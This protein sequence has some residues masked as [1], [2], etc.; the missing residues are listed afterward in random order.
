MICFFETAFEKQG[1]KVVKLQSCATLLLVTLLLVL[2]LYQLIFYKQVGKKF[3]NLN[4]IF[5]QAGFLHKVNRVLPMFR[6]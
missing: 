1:S 2:C 3:V 4:R 5:Q 6:I